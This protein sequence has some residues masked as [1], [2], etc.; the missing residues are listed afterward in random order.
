MN[1]VKTTLGVAM[2][3]CASTLAFAHDQHRNCPQTDHGR[4][5]QSQM[6]TMDTNHD[7]VISKDEFM[8]FHETKWN[9]LAE[10]QG[11]CSRN[12]R[13]CT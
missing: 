10:E 6:K 4:W 8:T 11:R 7:G 5:M 9:C 12:C 2:L 1:A 3:M 13:T